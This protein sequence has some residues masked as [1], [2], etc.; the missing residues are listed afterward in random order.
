[1]QDV[2]NTW[3]DGRR[4]VMPERRRNRAELTVSQN[5]FQIPGNLALSAIVEDY[6]DTNKR[7]ESYSASYNGSYKGISFGL[8]Y[9][10]NIHSAERYG[11]RSGRIYDRDGLF[12]LT[13][14]IPLEKLF[15]GHPTYVSY[16]MNTSKQGNTTNNLSLGGTLLADN[17]LSWSVM[18][19]YGSQGQEAIAGLMP[20]GA[21]LTPRPSSATPA[22]ATANALTMVCRAGSWRIAT[23]H[24]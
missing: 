14:S 17:N 20:T 16:M 11:Q 3:R 22:I 21:P 15:G 13:M 9:S 7:M 24:L 4:Y 10:Y 1:M 18:Q 6:W 19:G 23:A 12:A 8:S 2:L 5:L